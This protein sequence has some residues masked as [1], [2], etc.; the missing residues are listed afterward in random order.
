MIQTIMKIITLS[1][2]VIEDISALAHFDV[3]DFL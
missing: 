1:V 2:N 3:I